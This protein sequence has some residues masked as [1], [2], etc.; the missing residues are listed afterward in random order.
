M[1][2]GVK[3]FQ[4]FARPPITPPTNIPV[5]ERFVQ[6][7]RLS[8]L[9]KRFDQK[10]VILPDDFSEGGLFLRS[11]SGTSSAADKFGNAITPRVTF[12][13][14][15]NSSETP[16]ISIRKRVKSQTLVVYLP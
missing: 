1:T 9:R 11:D 3:A 5:I 6:K 2:R 13:F 16:I 12:H 8:S 14:S 10:T 7:P 15:P 4:V